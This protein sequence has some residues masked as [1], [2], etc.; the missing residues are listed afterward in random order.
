[1]SCIES[2]PGPSQAS[3]LKIAHVNINSVTAR[4][5]MDELRQF[6]DT[7]NIDILALSETKLDDN[8]HQDMYKINGFHAPFTRHRNR[9]GGG[10]ALYARSSLPIRRLNNLEFDDEEWIW[11]RVKTSG[12][13]FIICAVY[14]PPNLTTDRLSIFIDRLTESVT[15]A[16]IYTPTVIALLG[17]LNTGNIY[18]DNTYQHSGITTFDTQLRETADTLD[19]HQLITEPTRLTDDTSNLRDLFFASDISTVVDSG[20]LSS[21]SN[22]DHFPIFASFRAALPSKIP[23]QRKSI[24]DFDRLDADGLTRQLMS[25]DWEGILDKDVDTATEHFTDAIMKATKANIPIKIM[26]P[27]QNDKPWMTSELKLSI[28]KRDRLF[29]RAKRTNSDDDWGRWRNQR[30]I[31]TNINRRQ[32]HDHLQSQIHKL[33]ENKQNPHRYHQILRNITGRS[34]PSTIPPLE[35]P[36]G[37]TVTEDYDKANI[38]N[39][40]FAKQSQTVTPNNEE[41]QSL[42]SAPPTAAV[43]ALGTFTITTQETLN[44]LNKLDTNKSCGPDLLP[45]KI[46]KL[47]AII[48]AEPLTKLF[49]KSLQSGVYPTLWKHAN[50]KPIFKN[51]GSPSDPTNYRPISLLPCLSKVF[52]K[53]VFHHIYDHLNT[54]NLLTDRQSGYRPNHS[55]QLQLTYLTHRLYQTLDTGQDFTAIYLDI[56]KYFDK[57]WHFGLLQKCKNEFGITGSLFRWLRSYLRDRTHQVKLSETCSLTRTINAGCPQGSV[58]GPLLALIYLDGLSQRT[59]HDILFFADDTLLFATHNPD[60]IDTVQ[61]SLQKD[62]DNIFEYGREWN[63]TFNVDKTIQQ[64]FTNRVT[65]NSPNVT[66]GGATVPIHDSHKHLGL[67]FSKDLHFHDHINDLTKKINR[68]LSPIYSIAKFTPRHILSQIY[69]TYIQPYFDYCDV[70]YDGHITTTDSLRLQRLQN[71]AARLVTGAHFRTS[72]D[73]LRRDLG[74][75]SLDTRRRIHKLTLYYKLQDPQSQYPAYLTS[76]IPRTRQDDTGRNLRNAKSQSQPQNRLTSYQRSFVPATT[77]LWNQLPLSIRTENSL[78]KFKRALE[79][80]LG[81]EPAPPY[82]SLGKR[83][84]NTLHTTLRLGMSSLNAHKFQIQKTNDPSCSC[85]SSCET[86]KHFIFHC[87][88]YQTARQHLLN[89]ISESLH[90]NICL[91]SIQDQ[92]NILIHGTGLGGGEGPAVAASFQN[93]LVSSGRFTT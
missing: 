49:N 48:I 52:E 70:V 19:L 8:I 1:M 67:I 2:N 69:T 57:I 82:Y 71:R 22:L 42:Q 26:A 89:T 87:P 37:D 83:L 61:T 53:I 74:W 14:L 72:T 27:K 25:T 13:T 91:L 23:T 17:D 43:P 81:I 45:A 7:N 85:G 21:F 56:S 93:Y 40:H 4:G 78:P 9:H 54:N 50:I 36:D 39:N 58:L 88:I 92:F 46:L 16:Q 90:H 31:T 65:T 51:K 41:Q 63:I 5:R 47:T 24:W 62:L 66:F 11:A 73:G 60:N 86:V 76:I 12:Q 79:K 10:T 38:L 80:K 32:K 20:I 15:Q 44:V 84:G 64:T 3:T 6:V 34:K 30:N 18:L 33:L 55:T 28:R 75:D 59:K 29:K 68:A 35:T 77:K